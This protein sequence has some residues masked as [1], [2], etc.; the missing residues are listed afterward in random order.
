MLKDKCGDLPSKFDSRQQD[1]ELNCLDPNKD[2]LDAYDLMDMAEKKD[3]MRLKNTATETQIYKP[4]LDLANYKEIVCILMKAVD[5][6]CISFKSP[7]MLP[8]SF[9][10]S[11]K[12]K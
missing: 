10:K 12:D 3:F 5:D 4:Y 9:W 6:E 7:R 8:P 1:W 11:K 2:L